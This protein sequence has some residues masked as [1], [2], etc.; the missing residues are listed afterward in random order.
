MPSGMTGGKPTK[1]HATSAPAPARPLAH[2]LDALA[3][4]RD[5]LDVDRVVGAERPRQLEPARELVDDDDGGRAHVLGDGGRLDAEAAR[6]LDDD[7]VAER[8]PG[9]RAGRRCTWES[10]QFTG[11]TS[12]SGRSSGTREDAPPGRR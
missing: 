11:D 5:L 9:P 12:S 8:E 6:A 10:A 2:Q 1:S 3:A 4:V 7:A